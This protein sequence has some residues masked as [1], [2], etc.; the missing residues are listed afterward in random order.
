MKSWFL[1]DLLACIPFDLMTS[2]DNASSG[3][4]NKLLRIAR[5]PR[6]YRLLRITKLMK[7][8][9]VIKGNKIQDFF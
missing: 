4:Y 2:N 1:I 8:F 7:I 9:R 3:P 5:L 6:L